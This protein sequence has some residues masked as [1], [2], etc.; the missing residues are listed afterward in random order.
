MSIQRAAGSLG[1]IPH[2]IEESEAAAQHATRTGES[3]S[4]TITLPDAT[5]SPE[6]SPTEIERIQRIARDCFSFITNEFPD[7]IEIGRIDLFRIALEGQ[8]GEIE[9]ISRRSIEESPEEFRPIIQ[10]CTHMNAALTYLLSYANSIKQI[11]TEMDSD[12]SIP[13][14]PKTITIHPLY[15]KMIQQLMGG[16]RLSFTGRIQTGSFGRVV[17]RNIGDIHVASKHAST[18]TEDASQKALREIAILFALP[19]HQNLCGAIFTN[20]SKVIFLERA[21]RDLFDV[22]E[23]ETGRTL[24]SYFPQI[25]RGLDALHTTEFE[26]CSG[27]RVTGIVHGDIKFE[28]F[29]LFKNGTVKISDF[30]LSGHVGEPYQGHTLGYQAPEVQRE[31]NLQSGSDIWSFGILCSYALLGAL[32]FTDKFLESEDF[33]KSVKIQRALNRALG[34]DAAAERVELL[35]P[36]GSLQAII[37]QCL[38]FDP[39]KRP[40]ASELLRNPYFRRDEVP[41]EEDPAAATA[42]EG[43]AAGGGGA[44]APQEAI[45]TGAHEDAL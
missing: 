25:L 37:R 10:Q 32:P 18:K 35:D 38:Q 43:G 30:G 21:E 31:D 8:K 33:Q 26:T 42:A 44:G 17:G 5:E 1:F 41:I 2:C 14:L 24:L 15:K 6:T 3:R 36:E 4:S 20:E 13:P 11:A 22:F 29:L 12:H 40:T 7:H 45:M 28:N 9:E 39:A 16:K 19:R 23:D 27:E 34:S